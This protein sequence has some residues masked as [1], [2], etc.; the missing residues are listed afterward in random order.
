VTAERTCATNR[1]DTLLV[2]RLSWAIWLLLGMTGFSP[3]AAAA[4]EAARGMEAATPLGRPDAAPPM[5]P[6]PRP[7]RSGQRLDGL[8]LSGIVIAGPLRFAAVTSEQGQ[9]SRDVHEGE[10]LEGWAVVSI[11]PTEI[12]LSRGGEEFRLRMMSSGPAG[13]PPPRIVITNAKVRHPD[14]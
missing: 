4:D 11:E 3:S 6:G 1:G 10:M 2:A 7:A 14:D 12:L 8:R 5:H 13:P 9:D